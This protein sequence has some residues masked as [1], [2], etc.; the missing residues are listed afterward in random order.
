[1]VQCCRYWRFGIN[2]GRHFTLKKG[3]RNLFPAWKNNIHTFYV[4]HTT[5]TR[6][7]GI[8]RSAAI[9]LTQYTTEKICM[10]PGFEVNKKRES[11]KDCFCALFQSAAGL[12]GWYWYEVGKTSW[13]PLSSLLSRISAQSFLSATHFC[14]VDVFHYILT[15]VSWITQVRIRPWVIAMFSTSHKNK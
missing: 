15:V 14:T 7:G 9:R 1:M 6:F 10:L 3:G 2:C 12:H 11:V 4:C 8:P 13:N 5:Y